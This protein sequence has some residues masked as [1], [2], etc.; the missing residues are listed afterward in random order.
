MLL[1]PEPVEYYLRKRVG[2][3][4]AVTAFALLAAGNGF[5]SR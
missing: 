3:L 4:L 1:Q 5:S 2:P